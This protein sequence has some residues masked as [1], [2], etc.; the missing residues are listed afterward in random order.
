MFIIKNVCVNSI[1]KIETIKMV[2]WMNGHRSPHTFKQNGILF[3][4]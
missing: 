1:V 2:E 3:T 4:P